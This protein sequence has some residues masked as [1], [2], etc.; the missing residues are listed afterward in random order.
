M[1]WT[2][3][4]FLCS[5]IFYNGRHHS[6]AILDTMSGPLP[7]TNPVGILSLGFPTSIG[8]SHKLRFSYK[9]PYLHL[10]SGGGTAL[11]EET[12]K[13]KPRIEKMWKLRAR[14]VVVE[15]CTGAN[16]MMEEQNSDMQSNEGEGGKTNQAME[17]G[18]H[19]LL[20]RVS[21]LLEQ[22]TNMP[23]DSVLCYVLHIFITFL[24][25]E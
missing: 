15:R 20:C 12:E 2:A 11:Q 3:F 1:L 6:G 17:G 13:K 23:L 8:V 24:S 25:Y 7:D 5:F 18:D 9:L 21:Y 14:R 19:C 10:C 4:I 16:F 22:V